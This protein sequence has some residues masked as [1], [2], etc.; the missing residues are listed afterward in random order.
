MPCLIGSV[1]VVY[2]KD[3]ETEALKGAKTELSLFKLLKGTLQFLMLPPAG[4]SFYP[5]YCYVEVIGVLTSE[6]LWL[7]LW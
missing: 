2:F 7:T 4:G 5:L 6:C 3:K 1:V